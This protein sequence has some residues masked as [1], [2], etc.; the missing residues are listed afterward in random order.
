MWPQSTN[1]DNIAPWVRNATS[2][3][4]QSKTTDD[5]APWVSG[6]SGSVAGAQTSYNPPSSG[7]PSS[8]SPAPS[9][10][11]GGG[12]GQPAGPSAA[13]LEIQRLNEE[14]RGA[15]NSGW[16]TYINS[17]NQQME[18]LPGQASNLTGIA[19]NQLK[20]GKENLGT[21]LAS[22]QS[23]LGAERTALESNQAKNL[24]GIA[25]NLKNMF[26]AGNV[27]LGSRGAGDS[28][29]SGQYAHAL[30]KVGSRARGN[31]M[32]QTSDL[33]ADI[34]RRETNLN[35][36]YESEMKNIQ[37]ETDSKVLEIAQ[38]LE[39]QK[40][41]IQGQIGQAGVGRSKD[42]S[43]LIDTQL[44]QA[45]SWLNTAQQQAANKQSM[46]EQWAV[47]QSKNIA[48]L[49]SN[50]AGIS[51]VSD[52]SANRPQA[53]IFSGAPTVSGGHLNMPIY[54]YG[55]TEKEKGLFG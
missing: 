32:S 41:A 11:T 37:T 18:G 14:K 54:G 19:Q 51:N 1:Q 40:N 35:R 39:G 15:I 30:T 36:V 8:G 48:Q 7:S 25:E 17:L 28:S 33:M 22:G 24:R 31:V 34:G 49:K 45:L 50:L 38:W 13:E 3:W 43:A 20:V 42:I 44:N 2:A 27:Y 5:I 16:D 21:S 52:I 29:A 10:D 12:G 6:T 55:Q 4:P 46:L 23:D 9:G 26:Q 47:G 53:G